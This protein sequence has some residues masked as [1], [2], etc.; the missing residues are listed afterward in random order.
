[1]FNICFPVFFMNVIINRW[2][3]DPSQNALIH[4]DSAEVRRLGEFHYSLLKTF[5]DNADNVLSR[6]YLMAE[7]W[8]NRVVGNNSL[9]TA[10]HA[11]RHALDDNGKQQEIIKTIP[12]KGY[13]FSAQFVAFSE[14]ESKPEQETVSAERQA[15]PAPVPQS[16][17]SPASPARPRFFWRV[18]LLA[19]VILLGLG[20]GG[21]FLLAMKQGA[22]PDD[23]MRLKNESYPQVE[24]IT[25]HHL[26]RDEDYKGNSTSLQKYTSVGLGK[27]NALLAAHHAALDVYYHVSLA[28]FSTVL[29]VRDRCGV[30]SQTSLLMLNWQNHQPQ[31]DDAIYNSVERTLNA[32]APCAK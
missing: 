24:H 13:L 6:Q 18:W 8:K 9:P 15:M 32:M 14:A 7:V 2:R 27:V 31:M 21:Y 25:I 5:I 10:I 17:V 29:L 28:R 26:Y 22:L 16:P 11:L 3:L 23:G 4:E 19:F 12:K 20:V 1:M 30:T